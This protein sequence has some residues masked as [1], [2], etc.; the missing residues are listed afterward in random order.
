MGI[1]HFVLETYLEHGNYTYERILFADT[2]DD[3]VEQ[4]L[5]ARYSYLSK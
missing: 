4:T 3:S 5:I 1:F 2:T